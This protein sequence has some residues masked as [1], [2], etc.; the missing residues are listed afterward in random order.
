[1]LVHRKWRWTAS[2]VQTNWNQLSMLCELKDFSDNIRKGAM[3]KFLVVLVAMFGL[4]ACSY[5][6]TAT[7]A[8]AMYVHSSYAEKL[9]GRYAVQVVTTG[10]NKSAETPGWTCSAHSFPIDLTP[11]F[12][13]S[14]R[15]TMASIVEQ[16]DVVT[17]PLAAA[18]WSSGGYTAYIRVSSIHMNPRVAFH[19]GLLSSTAVATVQLNVGATVQGPQGEIFSTQVEENGTAE[20]SG[21]AACGGGADALSAA[22]SNALRG[23]MERLAERITNAPRLRENAQSAY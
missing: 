16:V 1:M 10:L 6:S 14:V 2:L 17:A 12:Q 9:S 15:A 23:T 3:N 4:S 8:P 18:D 22:A 21:G 11:A 5:E 7:V 13:E 20:R 19:A